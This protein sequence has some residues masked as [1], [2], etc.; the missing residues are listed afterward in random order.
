MASTAALQLIVSLQDKASK[1]LGAIG[2]AGGSLGRI[3]EFAAGG[4]VAKGIEG[5]VGAMGGLFDGVKENQ[6]AVAQLNSVLTSTKGVANVTTDAAQQLA[7]SLGAQNGLSRATSEAIM[8]GE[9]MLLTFTNI[10]N[11]VKDTDKIFDMATKTTLDMATAMNGG[12]APSAEQMSKQAIQLGKALNDPIKGI[13][14]LSKVGVTFTDQQK[15]QIETL[16]KSGDVMG[17]QK[18][19][20]NE[21]ATE[22]GGAAAASAQTFAGRMD[23]LREKFGDV[24]DKLAN[25]LMPALETVVSWLSSPQ[26]LSAISAMVDGLINGIGAAFQ[27]ISDAGAVVI[28]IVTGLWTAFSGFFSALSSGQDIWGAFVSLFQGLG[29][30]LA[31]IGEAITSWIGSVVPQ[32][33]S[34]IGAWAVAFVEWVGPLIPGWLQAAGNFMGSMLA[35]IS[36]QIPGIVQTLIGWGK[37]FIDWIGPMLPEWLQAAGEFIGGVLAWIVSKIPD[38][39]NTIVEWGAA[40]IGWIVPMIP[41][42]LGELGK[43]LLA[44]GGWILDTGLPALME[45]LG[46]WGEAFL[47]WIGPI[48]AQIPGKLGELAVAI[49]NWIS[50]TARDALQKAGEIGGKLIDG[51]GQGFTQFINNLSDM[52][53]MIWNWISDTATTALNNAA[54]IGGKLIDGIGQGFLNFLGN[55]GDMAGKIW[56]WITTTATD[57]YTQAIEIGKQLLEGIKSGFIAAFDASMDFFSIFSPSAGLYKQIKDQVDKEKAKSGSD[58]LFGGLV[59]AVKNTI[60]ATASGVTDNAGKVTDAFGTMGEL[61]ITKINGVW[62]IHS[63]STVFLNIGLMAM[64]GLSAGI[65]SGGGI[66]HSAAISV[67]TSTRS[68]VAT[69][70]ASGYFVAAGMNVGRGLASGIASSRA[71]AISAALYTAQAVKNTVNSALG[72]HS[73]STI[74]AEVGRQMNAGLAEGLMANGAPLKATQD[75]IGSMINLAKSVVTTGAKDLMDD[76]SAIMGD[77]ANMFSALGTLGSSDATMPTTGVMDSFFNAFDAIIPQIQFRLLRWRGAFDQEKAD[78]ARAIGDAVDGITGAVS[79]LLR[80]ADKDWVPPT[81][82]AIAGFFDSLDQFIIRM[83]FRLLRWFGSYDQTKANLAKAIGDSVEG[84]TQAVG[85]LLKLADNAWVAPT[86][87][88]IEGFFNSLD[89]FIIRMDFRLLRWF[90]SYDTTKANLAKAIGDSVEGL[91][92]AVGG[93]VKLGDKGWVA[94]AEGAIDG[95]FSALDAFVP[96]LQFRLLRWF[97]AFDA[98][99]ATLA[100][101]IGDSVAGL[102][103]ALDPLVRLATITRDKLPT[104]EIIGAFLGALDDFLDEFELRAEEWMS[105]APAV[106]AQL[107]TSI[108]AIAEGIGKALD[109]LTRMAAAQAVS[110][111]Q[112]EGAMANVWFALDQFNR[113]MTGGSQGTPFQGSWMTTAT[114]FADEV[115]GIF[116]KFGDIMQALA[117]VGS[118]GTDLSGMTA[119]FDAI[120]QAWLGLFGAPETEGS[121]LWHLTNGSTGFFTKLEDITNTKLLW[122]RDQVWRDRML[123]MGNTI[124]AT[125]LTIASPVYEQA[126]S[127]GQ[128]LDEGIAAGISDNIGSITGAIKK[129]IDDAVEAAKAA[130]GIHSPSKLTAQMIGLPLSQGVAVGILAGAGGISSAMQRAVGASIVGASIPG[131]AGTGGNSTTY[132]GHTFHVTIKPEA[133]SN[134]KQ[135]AHDFI[136][137][138]SEEL[139][140]DER[141]RS[142]VK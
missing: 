85:G 30:V 108:G 81:E 18:V 71:L 36:D 21:L 83:D 38:I 9:S 23:T 94:P 59:G 73:P 48:A 114:Q 33:V 86:T 142:W 118:G 46:K 111:G 63:P 28:P 12:A 79:G 91:L 54:E 89:E 14:A 128:K 10:R 124:V 137:T 113:V 100:R 32:I 2:K 43:L 92:G 60:D 104:Q 72:I 13:G 131:G 129:A 66:A 31:P 120:R 40:L 45:Q 3:L 90:G 15:K 75:S 98:T 22:F 67:A 96:E 140:L 101:A 6:Q 52:A 5:I 49:W 136:T 57:A 125:L 20:L 61:A 29:T 62:G 69:N 77:I 84:L 122:L 87:D 11:G 64:A 123:E 50:Q 44:I 17:A 34:A 109:P 1:P 88:A 76:L 16:V 82:G 58:N 126:K 132:G 102:M 70:M 135:I 80:L 7:D 93:L 74:M 35:W 27:F 103:G 106:L 51:I 116:V 41:P 68:V 8:G 127:L 47:N 117:G 121:L 97:G 115:A 24:Q 99:K 95:F 19:I 65:T 42:L 37:A 39:V 130:A 53:G 56:S 110:P 141:S 26:V 107:S 4:I 134:G 119:A 78:L 138:L 133:G 139:G 112:I 25:A 105:K 55:L